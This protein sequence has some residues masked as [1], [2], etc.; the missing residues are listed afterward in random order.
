MSSRIFQ[1]APTTHNLSGIKLES[2][3]SEKSQEESKI[4]MPVFGSSATDFRGFEG[5]NREELIKK[6]LNSFE[7]E[8]HDKLGKNKDS[9]IVFNED[10]GIVKMSN[11]R[12]NTAEKSTSES[13]PESIKSVK[14]S[15]HRVPDVVNMILYAEDNA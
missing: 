4:E 10:E 12:M 14:Y 2:D 6:T 3:I 5:F 8:V 1:N 13:I 11:I 9:N 15:S 7:Q